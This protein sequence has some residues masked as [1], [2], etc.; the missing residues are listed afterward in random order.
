M[1]AFISISYSLHVFFLWP[2]YV[3]ILSEMKLD[4]AYVCSWRD[5]HLSEVASHMSSV[6]S[7]NTDIKVMASCSSSVGII[8]AG[9][10]VNSASKL[11]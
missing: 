3:K 11:W 8:P 1:R 5:L 9:H 10:L 6:K 7:F 2:L 4:T